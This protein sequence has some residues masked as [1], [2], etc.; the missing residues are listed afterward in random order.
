MSYHQTKKASLPTRGNPLSNLEELVRT[1]VSVNFFPNI[2][3]VNSLL[4]FDRDPALHLLFF[5]TNVLRI[6]IEV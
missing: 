6:E 4:S 2:P 3:G 5:V 1:C